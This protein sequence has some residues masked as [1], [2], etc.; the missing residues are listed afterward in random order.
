MLSDD[1]DLINFER[2]IIIV[3]CL[4]KFTINTI[5]SM[6]CSKKK[7]NV[8]N[9]SIATY[10]QILILVFILMSPVYQVISLIHNV[11]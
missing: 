3:S 8:N 1:D 9:S 7:N 6:L 2:V 10:V 5:L 4:E 11:K